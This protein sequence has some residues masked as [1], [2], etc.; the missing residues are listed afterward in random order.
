[1]Q[2]RVIFSLG[3]V[4]P[5]PPRT[6]RGT[7]AKA[8]AALPAAMNVRRET[9]L[10]EFDLGRSLIAHL[11]GLVNIRSNFNRSICFLLT[12]PACGAAAL[13]SPCWLA[14]VAH[15]LNLSGLANPNTA[16]SPIWRHLA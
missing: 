14:T 5:A 13:F 10:D 16:L 2:A 9:D 11:K 8:A 12:W 3:G 4:L 6:W 1:M 15:H 7:I